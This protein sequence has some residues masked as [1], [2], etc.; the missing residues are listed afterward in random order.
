MRANEISFF[1]ER[2]LHSTQHTAAEKQG[3]ADATI[4][5]VQLLTADTTREQQDRKTGQVCSRLFAFGS[6]L[7]CC[8]PHVDNCY[9]RGTIYL[10]LG[11]AFQA[12]LLV[13]ILTQRVQLLLS[14]SKHTRS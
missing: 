13:Y 7:G 3:H 8:W 5:I 9:L 1:P 14:A 10:L 4:D 12:W 6:L 2:R 11:G